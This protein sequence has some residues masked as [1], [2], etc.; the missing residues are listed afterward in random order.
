[1]PRYLPA[2]V[3]RRLVEALE[4]SVN[5]LCADALVLALPPIIRKV[6]TLNI[7][8]VLASMEPDLRASSN[9]SRI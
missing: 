9:G 4:A 8:G 3:D 6:E 5:R 2:D 7:F 1:M